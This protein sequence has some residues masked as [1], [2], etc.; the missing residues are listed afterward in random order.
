LITRLFLAVLTLS[1]LL[2]PGLR[3]TPETRA[4]DFVFET[5][6]FGNQQVP[7]VETVGWGFFRFFFN[8]DRSAA[9]VTVDLKGL[10][11]DAVISADIHRGRPGNNGPVVKHLADGGYIVTSA[12]VT[13]TRT[14]L[15]DMAAGNWY[16]S[17]KTVN[18]PDGELRG[19][20]NPP[21]GF[22]P[23]PPQPAA[24]EPAAPAPGI[25][26]TIRPPDT[27]DAGLR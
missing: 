4:A 27:G 6:M 15:E 3:S 13:F 26:V 14:E 5:Q 22:I 11:G 10:A 21:A 19:Q 20:I 23:S 16:I 18:H 9:D 7:P 17:L 24:P 25:G 2:A 12:R 8:E 1:F